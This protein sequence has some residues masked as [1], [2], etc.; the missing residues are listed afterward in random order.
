[1]RDFKK[2]TANETI[3]TIE[4]NYKE[5]RREWM[6]NIF[7]TEGN[8]NSNNKKYQFW[9]QDN[10][11]I[12]LDTNEKIEQCLNYTHNNPVEAGFVYRAEDYPWSSAQDYAGKKGPIE[13]LLLK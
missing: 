5:S 3:H 6:L 13:V 7:E 1:M 10:H 4:G 9:Q 8:R 12:Q 2:F 11:P